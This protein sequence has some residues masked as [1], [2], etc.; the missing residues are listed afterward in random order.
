MLNLIFPSKCIFCHRILHEEQTICSFCYQTMIE[1]VEAFKK[2]RGIPID[3]LELISTNPSEYLVYLTTY[4]QSRP[5]IHRWKYQGNRGYA[6]KFA[7]LMVQQ[8]NFSH[9]VNESLFIPI[10]LSPNRLKQRGFNQAYDFARELSKLTHIPVCN[11]LKRTHSTKA[12]SSIISPTERYEN[13]KNCM[14]LV[15][16]ELKTISSPIKSLL[17]VDDVYTT[18]STMREAIRVLK[19]EPLFKEVAVTFVIIATNTILT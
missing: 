7:Q 8:V 13:M 6:R 2:I 4:L 12:Q 3:T 15:K 16:N 1:Q 18:G 11:C 14:A 10:P 9:F 5:A 17:L 19:K